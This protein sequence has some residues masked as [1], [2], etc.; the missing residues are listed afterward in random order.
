MEM[1]PVE[2][3]NLARVGYQADQAILRIEFNKGGLY[4]YYDVPEYVFDELMAADSKGEY[5]HQN[6]YKSYKQQKLG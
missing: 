6:I 4:E 2:S 3:S 1:I 5:A